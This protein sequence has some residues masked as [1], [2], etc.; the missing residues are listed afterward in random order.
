NKDTQRKHQQ[1]RDVATVTA[2]PALGRG[3]RKYDALRVYKQADKSKLLWRKRKAF[4]GQSR[5]RV[6]P[7]CPGPSPGPPPSGT[8]LE[9]LPREARWRHLI[10][11][12][13]PSQLTPLD[14]E[15]E[16][17]YSELLTLHLRECPATLQRNLISAAHSGISFFRSGSKVYA[18][19][20]G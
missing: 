1:L 10:K 11:M 17:L 9:H 7:A 16:R 14:V 5:D 15:E 3:E 6:P 8:C 13:V 4:P 12:P 2:A 19:D 20:F 18:V